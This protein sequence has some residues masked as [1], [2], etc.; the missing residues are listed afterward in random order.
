MTPELWIY[1]TPIS[2]VSTV[3]DFEQVNDYRVL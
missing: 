2:S 1:V 3:V